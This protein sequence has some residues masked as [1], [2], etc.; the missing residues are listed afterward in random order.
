MSKVTFEN[1]KTCVVS[2]RV[3][4]CVCVCGFLD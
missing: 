2:F 4:Q 1:V 3:A